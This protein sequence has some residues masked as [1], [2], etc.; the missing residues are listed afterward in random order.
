ME[1]FLELDDIYLYPTDT[2]NFGNLG[3]DKITN[4]VINEEE[5]SQS[6]P[7]FTAPMA[8]V[9]GGCNY[10]AFINRGIR[11][12]LPRTEDLG[13]R[14][15]GC[16]YIFCAFTL[17][18]IQERFLS[19]KRI[20]DKLFRVCIENGNGHDREIINVSRALKAM[21]GN[22]ICIMAGNIGNPKLYIDYCKADID[23]ARVGLCSGTLAIPEVYGFHY[24]M[25]SLLL[26][27]MGVRNTSCIGLKTRTKIIADGGIITH[28]D[29]IKAMALGADYV[30]MG[31]GLVKLAEAAGPAI[32]KTAEGKEELTY[33]AVSQMGKAELMERKV[34]R[35]YSAQD[36]YDPSITPNGYDIVHNIRRPE[37][38]K[39]EWVNVTSNLHMWSLEFIDVVRNA[40]IYTRATNW[41]EFKANVKILRRGS[42]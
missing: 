33:G 26:D 21:Y 22:Q 11:P 31:R 10:Q 20:S 39:E 35:L 37:E 17:R 15:E 32:S 30:M 3:A 42:E 23:Y 34:K 16:Q 1:K 4:L 25:A 6:L 36:L 9:V 28:V 2:T 27:T 8:S 40:F 12:I 38:A 19:S 5:N 18:E 29:I 14:L 41:K 24:P 13:Y 7:I